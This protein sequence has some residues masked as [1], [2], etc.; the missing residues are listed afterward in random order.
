MPLAVVIPNSTSI[1]LIMHRAQPASFWIREFQM[2]TRLSRGRR[3]WLLP[4]PFSPAPTL[5]SVRLTGDTQKSE[6]SVRLLSSIFEQYTI[7]SMDRT[8][9]QPRVNLRSFR[10]Y[11]LKF[12]PL[13]PCSRSKAVVKLSWIA[14]CKQ[15]CTHCTLVHSLAGGGGG[16][17]SSETWFV[18]WWKLGRKSP[19]A[20]ASAA[21]CLLL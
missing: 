4:Y 15:P 2:S 17:G 9:A 12:K 5:L 1:S 3:I 6:D 20:R 10:S 18:P 19:D 21:W 7:W 8:S 16:G 13:L 11:F 14:S